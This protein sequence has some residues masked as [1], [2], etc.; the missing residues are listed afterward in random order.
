M[1]WRDLW[2]DHRQLANNDTVES[3]GIIDD[4]KYSILESKIITVKSYMNIESNEYDA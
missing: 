4:Q 1:T 2:M 3:L